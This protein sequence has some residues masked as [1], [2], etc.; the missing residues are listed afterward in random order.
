MCARSAL[1]SQL[2]PQFII[3]MSAAQFRRKQPP[4]SGWTLSPKVAAAATEG[5][6]TPSGRRVFL[7][8]CSSKPRCSLA[9]LPPVHE[10]VDTQTQPEVL[11]LV[12]PSVKY[13]TQP[14]V[15]H[16]PRERTQRPGLAHLPEE[17]CD[18][19]YLAGR[20][21]VRRNPEAE[22][23][24]KNRATLFNPTVGTRARY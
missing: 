8:F 16:S 1:F 22:E 23:Q 7:N 12:L 10:S 17:A 14:T 24:A 15:A 11:V 4:E 2:L 5:R 19:K 20:N 18:T 13:C 6:G 3:K 9:A 21:A